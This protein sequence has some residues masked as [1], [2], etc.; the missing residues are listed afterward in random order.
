M[1]SPAGGWWSVLFTEQCLD[2]DSFE[3]LA[4][5]H[6]PSSSSLAWLPDDN[7]NF[8]MAV[9]ALLTSLLHLHLRLRLHLHLH[10]ACPSIGRVPTGLWT[11]LSGFRPPGPLIILWLGL[12]YTQMSSLREFNLDGIGGRRSSCCMYSLYFFYMLYWLVYCTSN[13]L[14]VRKMF[15]RKP[16]ASD[17]LGNLF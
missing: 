2:S 11:V 3:Q 6:H 1:D 8:L 5:D 17:V 9:R 16:P 15:Y 14:Q 12:L 10:C 13:I 7:L 4:L